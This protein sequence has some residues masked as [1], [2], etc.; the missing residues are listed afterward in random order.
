MVTTRKKCEMSIRKI[1]VLG[2]TLVCPLVWADGEGSWINAKNGKIYKGNGPKLYRA[3]HQDNLCRP[4]LTEGELL[5][6]IIRISTVGATNLS[7]TLDGF[8]ADGTEID[9]EY[10][11]AAIRI[12]DDTNYRWI[13]AICNVLGTLGDASH[14]VRLKAAHTAGLAMADHQSMLYVIEGND[15]EDLVAAFKEGA[16]DCAVAAVYGGD[17]DLVSHP[18]FMRPNRP[19][20]VMGLIPSGE[21]WRLSSILADETSS[22][23]RYA[24]RTTLAAEQ[25]S[26]YNDPTGLTPDEIDQGFVMLYNGKDLNHWTITGRQDGFVSKG[27]NI[28][29]NGRGG[30]RLLSIKRYGDFILRLEYKIHHPNGN[31]GIFLR[32]PRANRESSM[33]MEFQIM[34]DHGQEPNKNSTGAIYDQVA[35]TSN[36]SKLEGTWNELEIQLNGSDMK[37][38]L[39]GVVIQDLDMS[40]YDSLRHRLREGFIALQ[41]HGD[42]ASYRRIRIKEL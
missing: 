19:G 8:S 32:A 36:P 37:A 29:W 10:V 27:G 7:F 6:A 25:E 16:P 34:G 18:K 42:P 9:E 12:K 13:N 3:I 5:T 22:Y 40:E 11:N 38:A 23:E 31:S 1:L 20:L 15:S 41:D 35:A 17:I 4:D 24:S 39:N 30:K 21:H 2:L 28:M 33:G 14:E 26:V